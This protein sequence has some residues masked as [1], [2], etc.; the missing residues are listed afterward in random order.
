MSVNKRILVVLAFIIGVLMLGSFLLAR[1]AQV[2]RTAIVEAPQA[3]VFALHNG[4]GR[5][6]E[7]SPWFQRDPDAQYTMEAPEFGEGAQVELEKC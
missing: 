2:E 3:T 5:F 1:T 7:W 6:N 4:Y